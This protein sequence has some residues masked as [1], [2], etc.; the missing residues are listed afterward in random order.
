VV[1]F[2]VRLDL[3]QIF[4]FLDEHYLSK[5]LGEPSQE[6]GPPRIHHNSNPL[7][8]RPKRLTLYR[9]P[10]P[11]TLILPDQGHGLK[12]ICIDMDIGMLEEQATPAGNK[13]RI[14]HF[15]RD[16]QLKS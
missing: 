6:S 8:F 12:K 13:C 2:F 14:K 15:S 9:P 4:L 3:D 5:K 7:K 10:P 11:L 16:P 1:K